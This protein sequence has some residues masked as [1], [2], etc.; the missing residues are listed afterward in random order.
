MSKEEKISYP[1][2]W[3]KYCAKSSTYGRHYACWQGNLLKI[4]LFG[5]DIVPFDGWCN[6]FKFHERY[7]AKQKTR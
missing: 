4:V 3:C 5:P 7:V 2:Q 1:P 6:K